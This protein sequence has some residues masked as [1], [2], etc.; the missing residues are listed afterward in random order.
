MSRRVGIVCDLAG[1][2]WPSMD[3]VAHQLARH[4]PSAGAITPVTLRG[5]TTWRFVR[6]PG[7]ASAPR[8]R[9]LDRLINRYRDY[10]RWLARHHD[11]IDVFHVIDHS[12]AH[13]VDVLPPGGTVVTC[14]DLD[15]FR[16]VLSPADEPRPRWFRALVERTLG[17]LRRAGRVACVSEAVRGELIAAGVVDAARARVVPNGVDAGMQPEP[18]RAADAAAERLL[19]PARP[20][21]ILHVGSTIGRKRLD[22]LL[23]A[24]ARIRSVRPDARLIRVGGL[25]PEQRALASALGLDGTVVELP[26]VDRPVLASIYRR[27]ALVMLPSDREGFG[28]P[29]AEALA[30]GTPVIASDIPSL[31]ETGGAAAVYASR[32]DA[33]AFARAALAL[34][35]APAGERRQLGLQHSAHFTWRTHAACM[36]T[37]YRELA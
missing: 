36:A 6:V 12:Y 11:G 20:A 10:P 14:H 9:T 25:G 22:I 26:F 30:C 4:L 32:G 16:P 23:R 1:E 33:A 19:G 34:L 29:I 27:S 13:L 21:D 8:V 35:E 31:R 2:A 17:G 37:L 7:F 5:P 15:A 28:L 3:L 18:R 24:F